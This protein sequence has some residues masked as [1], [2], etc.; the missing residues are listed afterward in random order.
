M[1][2]ITDNEKNNIVSFNINEDYTYTS[3]GNI[4]IINNDQ[5]ISTG[6]GN[7]KLTITANDNGGYKKEI[8]FDI[9]EYNEQPEENNNNN[10]DSPNENEDNPQTTPTP[11]ENFEFNV[12]SAYEYDSISNTVTIN[13]QNSKYYTCFIEIK[14]ETPFEATSSK[15][16]TISGRTIY[17][18]FSQVESFEISVTST[19]GSN[20][21]TILTINII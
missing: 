15:N 5:I 20:I 13:L 21:T 6:L 18:D 12:P 10:N 17:F 8:Y 11:E 19:D 7:G 16:L 3:E 14:E 2:L 4:Q 9:K 1:E